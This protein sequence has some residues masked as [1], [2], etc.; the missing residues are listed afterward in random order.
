MLH[1]SGQVNFC[2]PHNDHFRW[3]SAF[4]AQKAI[5]RVLIEIG[6]TNRLVQVLFTIAQGYGW[7]A[8]THPEWPGGPLKPL[9]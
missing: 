8:R 4:F 1:C 6:A 5:T 9:Y 7:H 3:L 2:A